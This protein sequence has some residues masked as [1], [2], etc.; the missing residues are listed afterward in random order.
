MTSLKE[1]IDIALGHACI[2]FSTDD[3][4]KEGFDALI[5][6]FLEGAKAVI[7]SRKSDVSAGLLLNEIFRSLH[8]DTFVEL[9]KR[10]RETVTLIEI[11]KV[12]TS[13]QKRQVLPELK[14][15]NIL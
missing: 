1:E 14:K 10:L 11:Y 8:P 13:D 3:E 12:G 5:L 9:A 6:F 15:R 7:S 2:P 4:A